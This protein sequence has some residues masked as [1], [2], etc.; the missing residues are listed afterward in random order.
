MS[1]LEP[2][3]VRVSQVSTSEIV[4]PEATNTHGTIF[5]GR[6]VSLMDIAC[7]IAA[8]RHCR[9]PVVTASIDE[10]HFLA[11]IKLGYV[12]E[13]HASV[14][15]TARSSMEV[16]VR[17]E[18]ENPR[19]GER[20]H[21]ASAYLT[22]VALDQHGRPAPVPPVVAET[23]DQRRRQ[24]AAHQRRALRLERRKASQQHDRQTYG[25][26]RPDTDVPAE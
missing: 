18:A 11:P 26:E 23:D 5:G 25:A 19:T 12:V 16:G 2:K 14:N 1:E 15:Y 24:R 7:S 17:V 9:R 22:F 10:V 13:L 8:S 3:P 6:V 20:S 21:T 4:L